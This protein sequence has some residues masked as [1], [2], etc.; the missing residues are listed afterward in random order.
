VLKLDILSETASDL[1]KIAGLW[2]QVS[3]LFDSAGKT[4][5]IEYIN[6]ASEILQK[7]SAMEKAAMEK[8]VRI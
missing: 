1:A 6:K 3:S 2:S 4:K 5:D 7:I 8:L